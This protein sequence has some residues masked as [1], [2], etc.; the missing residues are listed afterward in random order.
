[1]IPA[2]NEERRIVPSL[3]KIVAFLSGQPYSTKVIVVDDGS[4]D[5]TAAL[6]E[7]FAKE[8]PVISLLRAR[9]GGKGHVVRMGMLAATGKN[10]FMCDA[11]LSMPVEEISK[12]FPM[13]ESGCDIA[14]GSR[15]A[16]GASRI[17]EPAHR[18]V[19]GRVF[20]LIVRLVA[21][22]GFADTQCGFK[23][24]SGE[25]AET[26]FSL[27]TMDGWAFDVELLFIARKYGLR[28][29]EVPIHWYYMS[30]SKV[31]PI[32]DTFRMFKEALTVRLNDWRGRYD[33]RK[34]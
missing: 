11:D 28:V 12:F 24:F 6:V 23:C 3:E 32:R 10:R 1:M 4:T 2:Y 27:Q 22:R 13:M 14:I 21:V 30:S 17:A 7:E 9:H 15:E 16:P 31:S 29:V 33:C 25:A 26:V 18:H 5:D 34:D 8:H 20:N 19:M